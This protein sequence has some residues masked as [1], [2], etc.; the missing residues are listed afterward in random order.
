MANEALDTNRIKQNYSTE[1]Q[2]RQKENQLRQD[3]SDVTELNRRVN[4][5]RNGSDKFYTE[6]EAEV[7]LN[8]IG[9]YE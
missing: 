3:F 5:V 4:A 9:F 2:R 7:I 6:D 8:E 1:M